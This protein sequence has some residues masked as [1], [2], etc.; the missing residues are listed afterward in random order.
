MSKYKGHSFKKEQ[1]KEYLPPLE[2]Q[3]GCVSAPGMRDLSDWEKWEKS[4]EQRK[5]NSLKKAALER[6]DKNAFLSQVKGSVSERARAKVYFLKASRAAARDSR[7]GLTESS[8]I[9]DRPLNLDV[10]IFKDDNEL[11]RIRSAK[12]IDNRTSYVNVFGHATDKTML[13]SSEVVDFEDEEDHHDDDHSEVSV[14]NGCIEVE[15]SFISE[16]ASAAKSF[17]E[18]LLVLENGMVSMRSK[19]GQVLPA[20]EAKKIDLYFGETA[21]NSFRETYREL[22]RR[23]K[24]MWSVEGNSPEDELARSILAPRAQSP[25]T[26]SVSQLCD[27]GILDRTGSRSSRRPRESSRLLESNTLQDNV[28]SYMIN[29]FFT[30]KIIYSI[31]L[32]IAF[33][34]LYMRCSISLRQIRHQSPK[35]YRKLIPP[36]LSLLRT[37]QP[38]V[39]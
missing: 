20:V 39:S 26:S 34:L 14:D 19:Y 4:V 17:P 30:F 11:S 35:M 9:D 33:N 28:C 13:T 16:G 32:N 21:K 31:L 18:E 27:L 8:S 12:F 5:N 6:G 15:A 22:D 10:Q 37:S 2:V 36:L 1:K 24:I 38:Q 25:F 3:V 7:G 29:S 23:R